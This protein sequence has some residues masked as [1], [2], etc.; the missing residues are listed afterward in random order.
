MR[1]KRT[2]VVISWGRVAIVTPHSEL[3]AA[4]DDTEGKPKR[5]GLT[6]VRK[7][8][9]VDL[10]V[11]E[12]AHADGRD[13]LNRGYPHHLGRWAERSALCRRRDIR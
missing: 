7:R 4:T 11:E 5:Q 13:I 8:K 2:G 6:G 9:V 10:L 1:A 12:H 3:P